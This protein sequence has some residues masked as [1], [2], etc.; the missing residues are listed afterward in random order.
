[1]R[2]GVNTPVP[3]TMVSSQ[4]LS[5]MAPGTFIEGLS[6]VPQFCDNIAPDQI[7]GGQTGGGTNLNLRGVEAWCFSMADAWRR[8]I[9]SAPSTSASFRRN[10]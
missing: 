2:S 1:M 6:A 4:E 3:V 9:G 7:T 10:W 5:T 8:A